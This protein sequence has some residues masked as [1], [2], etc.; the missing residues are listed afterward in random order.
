VSIGLYTCVHCVKFY[1]M[2][3]TQVVALRAMHALRICCV[4]ISRNACNARNARYMRAL[5]C[6]RCVTLEIGLKRRITHMMPHDSP[7]NL[8]ICC[9]KSLRNSNGIT[10]YGS[11]KC[12]W[13]GLKLVTFD[14]KRAIT[15]KRYKIEVWFLLKSNRKSYALYQMAMFPMT[16]GD[17]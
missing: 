11:D 9:Q 3:E 16:F 4:K 13:G 2:D 12:R 10:P 1:A 5:H 8:V 17:P 7:G 14:E 6:V 15:Q